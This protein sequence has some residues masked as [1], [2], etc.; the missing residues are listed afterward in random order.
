MGNMH[1]RFVEG[2]LLANGN[3]QLSEFRRAVHAGEIV[4]PFVP[5]AI[6]FEQQTPESVTQ[7]GEIAA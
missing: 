1:N 3:A 5:D 4:L 7:P 2:M 6:E